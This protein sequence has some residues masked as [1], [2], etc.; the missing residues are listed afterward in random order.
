MRRVNNEIKRDFI[1]QWVPKG[2]KV[3]DAGC[4]QGGDIHKWHSLGVELVGFDPNIAA[5]QEARRRSS[6]KASW[7]TEPRFFV[8]TIENT[9]LEEFD[10]VCYNF[11]FHYQDPIGY[12]EILK[13]LK[14]GGLFIG[15]VPD[16]DLFH[17]S[18]QNGISIDYVSKNVISVY[19]PD[20]PYYKY[21]PIS[22]PVIERE[23]VIES[24][25]PLKLLSWGDSFS[26]YSKFVFQM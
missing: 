7:V 6:Q 3:L 15:I 24:L 23:K 25:K 14:S 12:P 1:Q 26:I 5:I 22:E 20:T 2:S 21:G 19:I 4:G 17:L 13:R 16:R 11:S 8:G 18:R 10:V 9:P